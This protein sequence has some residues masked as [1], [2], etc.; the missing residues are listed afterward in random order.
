MIMTT[1]QTDTAEIA[2]T[3][4]TVAEMVARLDG[5]P[6][7][8]NDGAHAGTLPAALGGVIESEVLLCAMGRNTLPE[9]PQAF[10]LWM[11]DN[12]LHGNLPVPECMIQEALGEERRLA[13][14]TSFD[15]ADDLELTREW[16][17]YL[18]Y[19][20]HLFYA[21]HPEHSILT[22]EETR[23]LKSTF[24][25]LQAEGYSAPGVRELLEAAPRDAGASSVRK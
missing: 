2:A 12:L 14:G 23:A 22:E 11:L 13:D 25:A 6:L 19:G 3:S 5:R 17:N 4:K 18:N 24:D 16:A 7:Y 21:L 8:L 9:Q 20:R 1:T 15:V 10:R